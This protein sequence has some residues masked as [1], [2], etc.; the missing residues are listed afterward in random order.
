MIAAHVVLGIVGTVRVQ[1]GGAVRLTIGNP[2]LARGIH[3]DRPWIEDAALLIETK[4]S[5]KRSAVVGKLGCVTDVVEV[6]RPH[7]LRGIDRNPQRL[8]HGS[9]GVP[10]AGQRRT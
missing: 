6:C 1:H 8:A 3:G 2:G 7:V 4:S 10:G 5:G 9:R